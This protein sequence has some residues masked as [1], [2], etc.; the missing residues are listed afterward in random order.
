MT[1]LGYY[2]NKTRYNTVQLY[3]AD[4]LDIDSVHFQYVIMGTAEGRDH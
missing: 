3:K 4:S 2:F 1:F